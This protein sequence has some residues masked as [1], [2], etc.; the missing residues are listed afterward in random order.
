MGFW[1]WLI[2]LVPL[3]FVMGMAWYSKRFIRGVADFLAAGRV[4]GRYVIAV[5]G[6]SVSLS[7]MNLV[8]NAEVYYKTGFAISFWNNILLPVYTVLALTGFCY[9]RF[10][11]TRS[12]SVGQFLEMRY[13]RP[14][15]VFASGLRTFSEII[16]NMICPAITARF[17]I[18]LLG[19]PDHLNICGFQISVFALVIITVLIIS[20]SIIWMGGTLALLISDTLQSLISYP[21]FA[22]FVIFILC[23]FSYTG[24]IVPVMS[25]RIAGESFISPFDIS[26]LRDFN[27][28]A[29]V[30]TVF[31]SIL[32]HASWI[33]A[34]TTSA[35]RTPHEQKMAGILGTWRNGFSLLF[36][37]LIA[38]LLLVVLNHRNYAATAKNIRD[39]VSMRITDE[40]IPSAEMRS[41]LK[42][43]IAKIPEQLHEIGKNTPLSQEKNLDTVYFRT[44]HDTLDHTPGG[45][46]LFQE[47]RTLYNQ[48]LLPVTVREILPAG[49]IG[50]FALLMI[51][52]M[53]STDSTRIFSSS[54]TLVQDVVLPLCK[55]KQLSSTRHILLLRAM[56][57][58]VGVIFFCGSFFM[59]QL[60]YINLFCI[61]MTSI[62]LGGAGPVMVFGLYS[63]RGSATGAFASLFTGMTVA[64]SGILLQRNW[65]ATVYP[66]LEKHHW[67]DTIDRVLRNCSAPFEPYIMWRMDP[68]KFPIN[69]MEI[70][71]IAM[72]LGIIAYWTGS[73]LS[74]GKPFNLDRM[75]HRGKY[76]GKEPESAA[77]AEKSS[78]NFFIRIMRQIVGI[79]PDYTF[80][81]K[82]IAWSV[83]I[84]TFI[85]QFGFTFIIVLFWHWISPRDTEWWGKYFLIVSLI[86]PGIVAAISTV[87]FTIGGIK[88]LK[89]MFRDL[90]KRFDNPLDNGSVSGHISTADIAAFEKIEKNSAENEEK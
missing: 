21:I 89:Q 50:L 35:G 63:R 24:E 14:L 84:F 10:R 76:S 80:S 6:V 9:Y 49:L 62:W 72:F 78:A 29:L 75:L 22:I 57:A 42:E 55:E 23:K 40:K 7:V 59:A 26:S 77:A 60:D 30:V 56:S 53:I 27:L 65:A 44:V 18:Y 33:G 16:T 20:I 81:D 5:A 39:A 82:L 52:L 74:G 46:A 90:R 41:K 68:V 12:M 61:I 28:F 45:N 36:Y 58:L 13:N 85:Y 67:T 71:F 25:D 48:M 4:C 19:C 1:D 15:R 87:W 70:F 43:N 79:S 31:T 88:D 73:L 47:F 37:I 32:N 83:F 69:S 66:F 86:V 8:A 54:I 2:V 11:E 3:A 34:S 38:I 64:V 51:M 17:F